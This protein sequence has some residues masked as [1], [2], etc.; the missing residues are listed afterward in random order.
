MLKIPPPMAIIMTTSNNAG[1]NDE[2]ISKI[3]KRVGEV[4]TYYAEES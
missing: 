1:T 3:N 2:Q 4:R